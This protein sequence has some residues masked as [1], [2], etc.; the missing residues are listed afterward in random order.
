DVDQHEVLGE[1]LVEHLH[2]R[3][4]DS[5]KELVVGLSGSTVLRYDRHALSDVVGLTSRPSFGRLVPAILSPGETHGA[6]IVACRS[7]ERA[8][9]IDCALRKTLE[10]PPIFRDRVAVLQ[11]NALGQIAEMATTGRCVPRARAHDLMMRDSHSRQI[12]TP[13]RS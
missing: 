1:Q 9:S 2:I 10:H 12:S 4:E 5:G 7:S 6:L 13:W 8:G 3:R 11:T